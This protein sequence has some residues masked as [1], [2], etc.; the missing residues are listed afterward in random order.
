MGL[1]PSPTSP[2][3]S[4]LPTPLTR[5]TTTSAV[6]A[7]LNSSASGMGPEVEASSVMML[8]VTTAWEASSEYSRR[9]GVVLMSTVDGRL[10][11]LQLP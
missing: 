7:T 11:G 1:Q 6:G 4:Q 8:G 10:M 2:D 3:I 5:L 9:F